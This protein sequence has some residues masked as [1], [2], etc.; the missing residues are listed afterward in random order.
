M[1]IH[2][3]GLLS[4]LCLQICIGIRWDKIRCSFDRQPVKEGLLPEDQT[5]RFPWLG[6]IQYDF[7]YAGKMRYAITGAVRIH[8][9]YALAA[10][11][12]I[13]KIDRSTITN[14]THFIVWHSAEVK[15]Y[16]G[17]LDYILHYEFTTNVTLATLAM[18]VLIP[19]KPNKLGHAG[20]ALPICLPAKGS[21]SLKHLF[22]TRIS[23]V[24][25]ELRKEVTKVHHVKDHE[26]K[27]FYKKSELDYKM[28][29]PSHMVCVAAANA[30]PCVWDGGA[31]LVSRESGLYW[32]LLGF[33]SHG[34]GCGVPARFID[35]NS[36]MEWID[37][38]IAAASYYQCEDCLYQC[39]NAV[40]APSAKC[41]VVMNGA[42]SAVPW[43][44]CLC[45]RVFCPRI[46]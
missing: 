35:V 37:A 18:M 11:E 9:W 26:C 3:K 16:M 44:T 41:A 30:K 43:T 24:T 34:P 31:L 25:G 22:V 17:V 5:G 46:R 2:W 8:P 7:F 4:F 20:P 14:S 28:M 13:Y 15:Y 1:D 6:V 33:S 38:Q 12:D 21:R 27:E 29:A 45:S 19:D 10:A 23:D 32:T 42:R 40:Y 36:H 39:C